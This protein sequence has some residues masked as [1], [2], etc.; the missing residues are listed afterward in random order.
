MR[1][2][3]GLALFLQQKNKKQKGEKKDRKKERKKE[4]GG[5]F[6]LHSD[7]SG[8]SRSIGKEPSIYM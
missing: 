5:V 7:D 2:R 3:K 4:I 1:G 6:H 8:V